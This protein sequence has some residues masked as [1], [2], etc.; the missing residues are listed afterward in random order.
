MVLGVPGRGYAAA[1]V[2]GAGRGAEE[3]LCRPYSCVKHVVFRL[4]PTPPQT[5][6]YSRSYRIG[7]KKFSLLPRLD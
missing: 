4:V 7:A 6:H 2:G 5:L 1:V 3:L